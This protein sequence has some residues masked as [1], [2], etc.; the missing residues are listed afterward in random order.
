MAAV[1]SARQWRRPW[2]ARCAVF[3]AMML[4]GIKL[5]KCMKA[6]PCMSCALGKK[7]ATGESW[8]AN[9]IASVIVV[10]ATELRCCVG[11]SEL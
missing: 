7:A 5:S 2:H 4:A 9:T 3:H 11:A 8:D 6:G 1:S 10:D